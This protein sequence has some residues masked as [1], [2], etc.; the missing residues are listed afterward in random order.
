MI[1]VAGF[2]GACL[3]FRSKADMKKVIENL[4]GMLEW[5]ERDGI[6]PPYLY[7]TFVPEQ[8]PDSVQKDMKVL[9]RRMKGVRW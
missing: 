3:M 1:V 7:N 8:N 2:R 5:A 4:Q 6:K 9:K